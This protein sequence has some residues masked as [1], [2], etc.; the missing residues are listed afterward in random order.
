MNLGKSKHSHVHASS[1]DS[2]PGLLPPLFVSDHHRPFVIK[3]TGKFEAISP[4]LPPIQ[5]HTRLGNQLPFIDRHRLT[6]HVRLFFFGSLTS[7]SAFLF[8]LGLDAGMCTRFR[9]ITLISDLCFVDLQPSASPGSP[10]QDHL[11]PS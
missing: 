7:T 8:D 5:T 2:Y 3:A 1:Q 10:Q 11:N 4:M 9:T 6:P